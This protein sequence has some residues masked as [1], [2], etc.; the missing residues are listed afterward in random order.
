MFTASPCA[1]PRSFVRGGPTLTTFFV[2]LVDEGSEDN[3]GFYRSANE[4]PFKWR[5]VGGPMMAQH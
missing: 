5:F 1:D 2:D 3:A 4:T